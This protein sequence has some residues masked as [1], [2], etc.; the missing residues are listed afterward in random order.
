[1]EADAALLMENTIVPAHLPTPG[2]NVKKQTNN[3]AY[4]FR[5]DENHTG[6][7]CDVPVDKIPGLNDFGKYDYSQI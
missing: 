2:N 6:I 1:M 4:D 5:C 3:I 7:S